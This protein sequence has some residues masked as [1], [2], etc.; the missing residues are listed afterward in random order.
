LNSQ[1]GQVYPLFAFILIALVAIAALSVDFGYYRYQERLQQTAVDSAALA[2][3]TESSYATPNAQAA[4]IADASRNGFASPN[5][6]VSVDPNYSDAYTGSGK[7]VKVTITKSYPRFFGG[8][9]LS[10]SQPV[11]TSAVAILKATGSP[12]IQGMLPSPGLVKANGAK[13]DGPDCG[14]ETNGDLTMDGGTIDLQTIGY[15]GTGTFNGGTYTAATPQP[16]LPLSDPCQFYVPC[17]NIQTAFNTMIGQYSC[18]VGGT[19]S[20]NVPPGCYDGATFNGANF[21]A[22]GNAQFIIKN[23]MT[24]KGTDTN[25]IAGVTFIFANDGTIDLKTVAANVTL[26][27]PTSSASVTQG[28]LFYG[29][30]VTSSMDIKATITTTGLWYMPNVPVTFDGH[31]ETF[32]GDMVIGS[33]TFN[34]GSSLTLNPGAGGGGSQPLYAAI[35]E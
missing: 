14:L 1:R 27:A 11:T 30:A 7:G 33:G 24:L 10:G 9:Y 35:A 23:G 22:T 32:T 25:D 12:C 17:Q 20:G 6:T 18:N 15:A 8:I 31:S 4:A 28:V 16:Q 3:A 13:I 29:P 5:A 34:G 21:Q 2:G 19:Y 26:S